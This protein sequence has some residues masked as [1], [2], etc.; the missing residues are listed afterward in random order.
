MIAV[1]VLRQDDGPG[2]WRALPRDI[3]RIGNQAGMFSAA[4]GLSLAGIALASARKSVRRVGIIALLI[5]IAILSFVLDNI[6][7]FTRK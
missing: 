5:N 3:D 4:I 6:F 7:L 2:L 1:L